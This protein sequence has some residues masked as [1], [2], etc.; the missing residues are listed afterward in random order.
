MKDG[1]KFIY[2]DEELPPVNETVV[3]VI[4][5]LDYGET[6]DNQFSL[7]HDFGGIYESGTWWTENDWDEGQPW[8]IVGWYREP[9][10]PSEEEIRKHNIS[11][12]N[13]KS[14]A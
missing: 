5:E 8:A 2:L 7:W 3:V 10:L 1:C 9:K 13:V 11:W 6:P 4:A 14:G 12:K